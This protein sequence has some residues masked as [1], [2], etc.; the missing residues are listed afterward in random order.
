V[1]THSCA[2]LSDHALTSGLASAAARERSS[3][4]ELIAFIAEF[5]ARGLYRAAGYS[6][7]HSY[8]QK[9]LHLSEDA[10][11]KRI[12]VANAVREFPFLLGAL[13]DGRLHLS[14]A[15]LLVPH[16]TAKN[17]EE[18]LWA[19]FHK[20]KFEIQQILAA[21]SPGREALPMIERVPERARREGSPEVREL[22]CRIAPAQ[23]APLAPRP[24][25]EPLAA[26]R[27]TVRISFGQEMQ[28][29]LSRAQELLAHQLPSGDVV[30]VLHNGLKALIRELEK[31]KYGATDN[32]RMSSRESKNPRHIPARVR[33][34]VWRRDQDRCTFVTA[35]GRRCESRRHSQFDHVLEV[36]RG[37]TST[38][39]NLRL[40]CGA[41]NRFTAE[42]TFGRDFMK[43]KI[44]ESREA[45]EARKRAEEVA[46]WLLALGIR[47]DQ[48]RHAAAECADMP[49]ATLEERVKA[50]PRHFGP[51]DVALRQAAPA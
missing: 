47:A 24:K 40:R 50:A 42:Q 37:G 45:S 25:V 43:S 35:N 16:L 41:H 2:H 38:I 34:A 44:E 17:A 9:E 48:A 29:D 10:S 11:H 23:L 39:E 14:G 46:P 15:N 20:S 36:A 7:M 3:I 6:S 49:G 31:R 1:K 22:S 4:A 32:P 18:L 51:R 12:H 19:C 30:Q 33:R 21:R 8:C 28:D 5:C 27:F 26:Q 13:A